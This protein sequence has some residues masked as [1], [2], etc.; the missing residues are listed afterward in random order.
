MILVREYVSGADKTN[1]EVDCI[2]DAF[3]LLRKSVSSVKNEVTWLDYKDIFFHGTK[4][5][6]RINI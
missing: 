3:K 4:S 6:I 5:Y 2:E 1:T